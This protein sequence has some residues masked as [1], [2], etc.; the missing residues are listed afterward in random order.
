MPESGYNKMGK[1]SFFV[2]NKL[3][4]YCFTLVQKN[5]LKNLNAFSTLSCVAGEDLIMIC[6]SGW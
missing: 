1:M 4:K 6:T 3:A 2:G 5:V